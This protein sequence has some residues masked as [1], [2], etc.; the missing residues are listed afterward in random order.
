MKTHKFM[1]LIIAMSMVLSIL[2]TLSVGA[3]D[4]LAT[5]FDIKTLTVSG[6]VTLDGTGWN[7]SETG[8]SVRWNQNWNQNGTWNSNGGGTY[9][10]MFFASKERETGGGSAQATFAD[11]A[12]TLRSDKI[13]IAFNFACQETE[14]LY[15]R[16]NF[17]DNDNNVFATF[18]FDKNVKANVGINAV[19]FL[20]GQD[21]VYG[22]RGQE[23]IITAEKNAN[24]KYTVTYTL[25]GKQLAAEELDSVNGFKSIE[26]DVPSYNDKWAAAALL[27]LKVSY[28]PNSTVTEEEIAAYALVNTPPQMNVS[29]GSETSP[30]D[31]FAPIT[32][33][34][35]AGDDLIY[36]TLD[37]TDPTTDS[38]KYTG[39]F[40]TN[41]YA[42]IKACVV[43]ADGK[44][45]DGC[46]AYI[47]NQK[48]NATAGE[49]RIEGE[50]TVNNVKIAWPLYSGAGRYEVY[51][52]DILVGSTTGDSI[53]E[54]DLEV[55]KNYT[56]TVKALSGDEVLATGTTNTVTTFAINLDELTGYDDNVTGHWIANE[57]IVSEP[58]PS[59][60]EIGGKYYKVKTQGISKEEFAALG[61]DPS[62]LEGESATTIRYMES[63][64]GLNWPDEWQMVYPIFVNMRYEGMQN[65][66]HYNKEAVIFSA[67]AESSG[68]STAKLF[69]ASFEPG[70]SDKDVEPYYITM[71]KQE[72]W[73]QYEEIPNHGKNELSAYYIGRPFGYDSRDMVRFADGED[74]YTFSAANG[75][76][77]MLILKLE[78]NWVKPERVMNVI[79]HDQHQESPSVFHEGDRYYVYT[80]TTNGWFVSQARYSSTTALDEPWS[81]L[82]EVVNAGTY[83]TQA[84]G[85]WGYGSDSG[86]VVQRAHG[87]NWGQSGGWRVDNHQGFWHMVVNDGIATCNWC[88]KMEY[89]PYW[90]AI[91]VQS[92]E[93]V[94]LGK[95]A[96][97]EGK[98][99]PGMTDNLQFQSSPVT[100]VEKLPYDIIIDLE[101]PTVI[102]E[103]NLTTDIFM[104]SVCASYYKVYGSNDMTNWTEISD[105]TSDDYDNPTFRV[106]VVE[107]KTPYRYVKATVLEV[108]NLQNN[109]ASALWGGKPVELA[110]YGK[111]QGYVDQQYEIKDDAPIL[112]GY[113]RNNIDFEPY[114]QEPVA[115]NNRILV[116]MR[117]IFETMGAEVNWDS[118]TNTVTAERDGVTISHVIGTN[119]LYVNGELKELDV[120]SMVLNEHTMVPLRAIAESFNCDVNWNQE[121][122]RAYIKEV[123]Q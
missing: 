30:V 46:E 33:T 120:E 19:D 28:A 100:E 108:K 60:Y 6:E 42:H 8:A 22:I 40:Y 62:V 104:G 86:R 15:Q 99:A 58:T 14:N 84:N 75:N 110:V 20:D 34:H 55:N 53:D 70:K 18:Y 5:A 7:P 9:G 72:P 123:D 50:N 24:G 29:G 76:R 64:D 68:Y 10:L 88:Y 44:R 112:V 41:G 2:P 3:A 98:D 61:L 63:D 11:A 85:V 71:S 77:D 45:S 122:R 16:W 87:Y 65:G 1:A 51:R 94:S 102:T 115:V 106:G 73:E 92:G 80:S 114:G 48:W 13:E 32:I 47:Y 37:G 83:G 101:V 111:P 97:V 12:K 93:Y 38:I 90:G 81:P 109:G 117:A 54:Y 113:N 96:T 118:D 107:D 52:D 4:G 78:D 91:A 69:F 105:V 59:G 57:N 25:N 31:T 49:F 56:Y 39:P 95:K 79:L 21:A 89:H 121:F 74:F 103:V 35:P 116:P 23:M 17:K 67:H 43:T 36:Y 66:L 82:R 119:Q 26:A 27:N